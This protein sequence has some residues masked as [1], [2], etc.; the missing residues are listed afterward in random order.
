DKDDP[1]SRAK[2][3][4]G[5]V[6][7]HFRA[8][9]Q[10]PSDMDLWA[11]CEELMLNADKRE[12]EL[13]SERG[14]IVS[15]DALPSYRFYLEHRAAMDAGAIISWPSVRTLYWLMRQ[16]AKSP[17][18]FAT[19]MQGD[20]RT[21][22]D[23]VFG[24]ITYWAQRSRDWMLFGACDPSMGKN[25]KSDPSAIVVGGLDRVSR[26]LH[27]MYASIKRRVPSKLE[28]DLIAV[29][30]EYRCQAFGFENNNAYEWARQ[31]LVKAGLRA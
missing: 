1:I 20:P 26:K 5:H 31:D 13:A 7:H 15:D 19:E 9:A 21:E 10:M 25:E 6:V 14:E 8:I 4:I 12:I 11:Q 29:Q 2:R 28:A 27:V 3:S 17:R 30:R 18:A 24:H 23:K 16:R 22:E